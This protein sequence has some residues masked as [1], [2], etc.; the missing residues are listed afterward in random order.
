M[1]ED[2]KIK[3]TSEY[4]GKG[5]K[6]ALSDQ[7]KLQQTAAQK[8]FP[9]TH[10]RIQ[11]LYKAA[12]A[13]ESK[14]MPDL[15]KSA[16]ADAKSLQGDLDRWAKE[17]LTS[18]K[19]VTRELRT[20]DALAKGRQSFLKRAAVAGGNLTERVAGA[21]PFGGLTSAIGSAGGPVAAVIATVAAATL[22]VVAAFARQRDARDMIRMEDRV[23]AG[24]QARRLRRLA[25][26][27]T[28]ESNREAELDFADDAEERKSRRGLIQKKSEFKWYNP[29]GWIDKMTGAS[30]N[31][32]EENDLAINRDYK[33]MRQAQLQKRQKYQEQVAPLIEAQKKLNEFKGS[34]AR[35]LQDQVAA[36]QEFDR[37]HKAG[38]TTEEAMAGANVKMTTIA[39]ERAGN[40]AKLVNARDGVADTARV[41]SAAHDEVASAVNAMHSTVL[42]Q[43]AEAVA[44]ADRK[45]FSRQ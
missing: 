9:E 14:G 13:Y 2:I 7:Q 6:A 28:A 43:H 38:A 32:K 10:A 20:Q 40:Y 12:A 37:L 45:V 11:Q 39:R 44:A 16:R 42:K 34:E 15:A 23:A 18:H 25:V 1:A 4:D 29:M 26:D 22:G 41:A 27:G 35:A 17:N 5:A 8:A 21:S 3:I 19:D 30:E 36:I 31:E 24:S 33:G